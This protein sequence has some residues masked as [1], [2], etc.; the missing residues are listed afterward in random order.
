MRRKPLGELHITPKLRQWLQLN[1]HWDAETRQDK[2]DRFI[3]RVFPASV[4]IFALITVILFFTAWGNH[5]SFGHFLYSACVSYTALF[6][7]LG[8]PAFI[9]SEHN[10]IKSRY[11]AAV[12]FLGAVVLGLLFW[13]LLGPETNGLNRFIS[14]FYWFISRSGLEITLYS[15]VLGVVVLMVVCV[16]VSY[17]VLAVLVAYFRENYHRILLSLEKNDDSKLC[18]TSR[19]YFLIPSIIDVTEVTLD[20][21][22]DDDVF[23]KNVFWRM[24]AYE[25][26]AG[27]IIASYLFLNPVFLQTINYGEMMVIIMLLSLFISTL[28]VPV[29]ILRSLGAAAHSAG[30][31]PYPLWQGMKNKLFHP[32]FYVG[33]F[34]TLMWI[35]LYTQMDG[36]RIVTHYVGYLIFMGMLGVIVSFTYVNVFYVPFKNGIIRNFYQKKKDGKK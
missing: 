32:A 24:L 36:L 30:N 28:V 29:S 35:S 4:I 9:L 14:G 11:T 3:F 22:V 17:G 7:I 33:L 34:L 6:I 1:P 10:V 21:E 8:I 15:T 16:L 19:K 27:L 20:P 2:L 31:R 23:Q 26:V 5:T 25:I 18:R 13:F 12:L